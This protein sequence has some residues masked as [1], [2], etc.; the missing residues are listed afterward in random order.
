M[1]VFPLVIGGGPCTFNPEPLA[2]FF[3]LFVIG[4]GEEVLVSLCHKVIQWKKTGGKDKLALLK[5]LSTLQGV[6]VPSFFT[7]DYDDQGIQQVTPQYPAY[8]RIKRAI[9]PDLETAAFP[10]RRWCPLASRFTT[11]CAWRSPGDV[12]GDAASARP[13]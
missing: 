2:D 6:Y 8:Q 5:T 12:P 13:A 3:D 7:V 1:P 11:A 9:L 4:D 10:R